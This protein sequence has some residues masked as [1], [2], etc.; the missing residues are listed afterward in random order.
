MTDQPGV[1]FEIRSPSHTNKRK[2]QLTCEHLLELIEAMTGIGDEPKY[3]VQDDFI[4]A[5]VWS[6]PH[7]KLMRPS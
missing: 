2:L 7:S 5:P 1:D 4:I 3:E 6:A